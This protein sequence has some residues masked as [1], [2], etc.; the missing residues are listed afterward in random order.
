MCIST[1]G[2]GDEYVEVDVTGHVRLT[3]SLLDSPYDT[4][5]VVVEATDDSSPPKQ[6]KTR[7]NTHLVIFTLNHR[8]C[9]TA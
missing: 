9:L 3:K 8:Q 5:Q 7:V 2:S 1:G 4:I 6:A